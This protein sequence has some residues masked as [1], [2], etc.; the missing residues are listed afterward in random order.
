MFL[1]RYA[2][3]TAVSSGDCPLGSQRNVRRYCKNRAGGDSILPPVSEMLTLLQ[4]LQ[5]FWGLLTLPLRVSIEMPVNA[6]DGAKCTLPQWENSPASR[7]SLSSVPLISV[8]GPMA[9][10]FPTFPVAAYTVPL[11]PCQKA[12]TCVG[13]AFKNCVE[14]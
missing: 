6:V 3:S 5:L 14:S 10:T 12:V 1:G 8:P 2:M 7:T 9:Y 11:R 4:A 13:G